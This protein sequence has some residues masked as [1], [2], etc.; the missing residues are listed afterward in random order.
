MINVKMSDILN[1]S[2]VLTKISGYKVYGKYAFAIARLVREVEKEMQTFESIRMELIRKYA[3][4]DEDGELV[5]NDGN[6]HLSEENILL[7]NAELAESLGQSV[8]LNANPLKYDWF[9]EIEITAGEAAA[10][11]PFMEIE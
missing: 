5:V 10:L 7:C 1:A 3:D 8:E 11:E 9:D 6:V 4:K 2:E